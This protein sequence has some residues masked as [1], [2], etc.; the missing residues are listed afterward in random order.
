MRYLLVFLLLTPVF[1]QD[2][3]PELAKAIAELN[4]AQARV[5]SIMGSIELTKS[6]AWAEVSYQPLLDTG[7][8]LTK[9]DDP[10]YVTV[11]IPF[12]K[13][14]KEDQLLWREARLKL[15][16]VLGAGALLETKTPWQWQ[17]HKNDLD[18]FMT[19]TAAVVAPEEK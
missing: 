17:I 3:D 2:V 10:L 13:A 15:L 16:E 8:T 18:K 9:G 1:A 12:A 6:Q 4:A 19:T 5:D 11:T 7:V 14:T